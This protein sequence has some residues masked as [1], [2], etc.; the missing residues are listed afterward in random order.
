MRIISLI[1]AVMFFHMPLVLNA[2]KKDLTIREYYK[3]KSLK[4]VLLD[5][6]LGYNLTFDY[7]SDDIDDVVVDEINI[8]GLDLE[9]TMKALLK[10]T[11]LDFSLVGDR[12]V[13][14]FPANKIQVETASA[15]RAI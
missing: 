8:K 4:L 9:T 5:L 13:R 2:Q 3:D 14:I 12:I 10:D 6:S 15:T 1:V 11:G 7:Q